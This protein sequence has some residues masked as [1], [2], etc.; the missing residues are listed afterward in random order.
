[1]PILGIY[2]SQMTG[3]LYSNSYE[4]I[5]TVTVGAGGSSSISFTGIPNTYKHLQL[6]VMAKDSRVAAA[7]NLYVQFNSDTGA[8]YTGHNFY[9]NGSGTAAGF[10]GA[11]QTSSA[12]MRVATTN[13]PSSVFGVGVIDILDYAN[14][15]K[16]KTLR[17]LS[18]FD[19][20]AGNGQIYFWSGLWM[21]TASAISTI[22]IT[23]VTSPIVQYSHFALYGVK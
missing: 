6:R 1:M 17:S 19:D 3:H 13:A 4:S 22:T 23:P 16:Y 8:N 12:L 7:S 18:G 2:A 14:T 11:S 20:N 9:G 21:N 10:D 5:S 15:N